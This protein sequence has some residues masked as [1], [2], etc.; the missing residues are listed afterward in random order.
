MLKRIRFLRRFVTDVPRHARLAYCLVRDPRV[1]NFT[2][3]AFVGAM[4]VIVTPFIDL[5]GAVPLIGEIDMLA[6]SLLALRLFIAGCPDDV[7][8]D[9]E[10]Q[11]L[12]GTSVFHEDVRNGER[13]ATAIASRLH[14][15]DTAP[16]YQR[17]F[18]VSEAAP[19]VT[20]L[21]TGVGR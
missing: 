10:Q 21:V 16:Q 1:P 6:L 17:E 2:K 3:L 18:E 4:G 8:A 20:E 15:D 5:P 12:E 11:I 13:I 14:H 7:V 19:A 9:V